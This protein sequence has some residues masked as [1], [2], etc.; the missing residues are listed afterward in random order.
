MSSQVHESAKSLRV[1]LDVAWKGYAARYAGRVTLL[2]Q[3][4]SL[5]VSFEGA[6][7]E[8]FASN[9]I[10]LVVLHRTDDAGRPVSVTAPDGDRTE[11]AFPTRIRPHQPFKD[12]A[13]LEWERDQTAYRL[14]F[15]GDVF[16]TE[17]QRN[18]TDASFKTYSTPL[19]KPFP[20]TH[21]SG[22]TVRQSIRFSARK[23]IRVRDETR[24]AVPELGT[25]TG[26]ASKEAPA[27][28]IP[29]GADFGPLLAEIDTAADPA[30]GLITA[31]DAAGL[32]ERLGL[33]LDARI[34]AATPEDAV[35][36]LRTLPL[37]RVTRLGVYDAGS[38]VTEDTLWDAVAAEAKALGFLGELIA[39][40]RSHFAE[41]NR[42]QDSARQGADG[43]TYS[44]TP[45]MH[46]MEPGAIIETLPMQTLTALDA[47]RIGNGRPLHIGPVTLAAR[48]NAVA[49]QVPLEE[50]LPTRDSLQD[51]A[52]AAAWLLGSV[53][54]L[55]MPGTGSISY[56]TV[57]DLGSPAGQLLQQLAAHR[58][59]EVLC[60]DAGPET[61]AVYPVR[62]PDGIMA[63]TA[64]LTA[65]GIAV[66]LVSPS[67]RHEDISLAPWQTASTLLP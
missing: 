60:T 14:A 65:D 41:L 30:L 42:N 39:G 11:S 1:V 59:S 16:E 20:V 9:R 31:A 57:A 27:Q 23:I 26:G 5:T 29:R 2:F 50:E 22:D 36:V 52:F 53:A 17:D 35:A 43:V 66:R 7:V 12:V 61:I 58:G 48:F 56:G 67:G 44:V 63:Y 37:G 32:A 13:A 24:G 15:D 64:N 62:S 46:A 28:T 33:P 19:S 54:A 51:T 34:V 49:T 38:H 21:R 6:A 4:E 25:S 40:A 3:S 18:W 47:L 55:T 10:G 8:D 45:Q